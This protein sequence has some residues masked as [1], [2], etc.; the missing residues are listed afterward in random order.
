MDRTTRIAVIGA[1]LGGLTVAAYLQRAGFPVTVYEQT[2]SFA[3]IGAGIVMGANAVKPLAGL[4][5][6]PGLVA[7]GIKPDTFLSRAWDTGET[8]YELVLDPASEQRFG[9]PFLNIHR[10]DLHDLLQSALKPG[11]IRFDHRLAGLDET[12]HAIRPRFENGA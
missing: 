4:G 1:G 12:A 6:G 9:G 3:R 11:T 7:A 2:A 10:A 5:L 8:L